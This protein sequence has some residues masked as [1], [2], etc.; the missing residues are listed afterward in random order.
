MSSFQ[1][2]KSTDTENKIGHFD[3][4]KWSAPKKVLILHCFAATM[5]ILSLR[6]DVYYYRTD[7][8]DDLLFMRFTRTPDN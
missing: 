5:E 4:D 8:N 6:G 1:D 3:S 2:D 7:K